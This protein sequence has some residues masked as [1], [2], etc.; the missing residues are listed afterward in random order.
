MKLTIVSPKGVVYDNEVEYIICQGNE[1]Q[2]G[3]LKDHEPVI[4]PI[5]NGWIKA[6]NGSHEEYFALTG[7]IVEYHEEIV[8]TIVQTIAMGKT[9][10]EA[11]KNL[12][13]LKKELVESNRVKMINF[14]EMEIELAKN[15]KEIKA[16]TLK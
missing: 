5:N 6:V 13:E 4:V 7:G 15:I 10:D 9:L 8:N 11:L 3:I 2:I 16:S 1:G 14:T 12:E